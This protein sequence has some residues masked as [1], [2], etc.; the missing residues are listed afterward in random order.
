MA[1]ALTIALSLSD[2]LYEREN[3][4]PQYDGDF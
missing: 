2:Y 1:D 3:S 4:D